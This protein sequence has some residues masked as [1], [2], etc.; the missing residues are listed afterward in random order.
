MERYRSPAGTVLIRPTWLK[1]R[2]ERSLLVPGCLC[3]WLSSA[4]EPAGGNC[5]GEWATRE[6]PS[7]RTATGLSLVISVINSR[8]FTSNMVPPPIPPVGGAGDDD[9]PRPNAFQWPCTITLPQSGARIAPRQ[10]WGK[11]CAGGVVDPAA[12]GLKQRKGAL[13]QFLKLPSGALGGLRE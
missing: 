10:P 13:A 5:V 2:R 9:Q 7:P 4:D 8:R 11:R 1:P 6:P 3:K 12:R